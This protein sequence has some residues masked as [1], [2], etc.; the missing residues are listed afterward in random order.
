MFPS[1]VEPPVLVENSGH[2]EIVRV[3]IAFYRIWISEI[4]ILLVLHS[5]MNGL[6]ISSPRW[7]C[8]SNTIRAH[9]LTPSEQIPKLKEND[10]YLQIEMLLSKNLIKNIMYCCKSRLEISQSYSH[11]YFFQHIPY[12]AY[13][14][15]S[16]NAN[17][18]QAS[19][20]YGIESI[21]AIRQSHRQHLGRWP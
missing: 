2:Y 19:I 5:H 9:A 11:L 20:S 17:M 6:F 8:T 3:I 13:S 7:I 1:L 14:G 18:T 21:L 4:K 10:G 12:K 15:Q 16:S